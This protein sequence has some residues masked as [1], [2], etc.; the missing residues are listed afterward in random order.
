MWNIPAGVFPG[1]CTAASP[2]EFDLDQAALEA[3]FEVPNV[4]GIFPPALRN[5]LQELGRRRPSVLLAFP[6]KAAGT[7]LRQAAIVAT[8]GDLIRIVHAQ[9]GR[10]AQPYL[11]TFL[12][13]YHGGITRGPMVAHVHM[14]ALPA[15]VRFMEAFGL[16]PI[17]MT[18]NIPDM[19]ASYWDMLDRD[20]GALRQGLNCQIPAD[21]RERDAGQKADF[22]IDILGPWYASFYATWFG[23]AD[24]VPGSVCSLHYKNFLADPAATLETLLNHSRIEISRAECEDI[25]ESIWADRSALR[26][27][28]GQEGRAS[29]YFTVHHLKR[30][31]GMLS[32]FPAARRHRDELLG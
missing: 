20:P 22:L 28:A 2:M 27:N 31:D 26:F 8:G 11:P 13:Y 7:F 1:H 19:L 25:I 14:Q 21:W 10:D 6:P 15:N 3:I 5:Y 24:L 23:L 17:V 9:G 12:A 29:L 18:R 30:L 16:R 4:E 32:H